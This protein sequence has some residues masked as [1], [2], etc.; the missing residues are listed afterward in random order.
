LYFCAIIFYL[1]VLAA[2]AK[3]ILNAYSTFNEVF[4]DF[5][6]NNESTTLQAK[7][8]PVSMHAICRHTLLGRT[9]LMKNGT[10]V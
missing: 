9:A 8:V 3:P 1:V 2:I 4:R 7:T 6:Q 10:Q 5:A